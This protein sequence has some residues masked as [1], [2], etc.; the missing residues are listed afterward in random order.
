MQGIPSREKLFIG[1]DLNGHVGT[2]R[3]EF[4]SVHGGF[5]FRK[6]KEPGNL[7]LNF[8]LSYDLI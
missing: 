5:D 8:A 1:G 3:Y 4:D 2:S 7:I 6:R